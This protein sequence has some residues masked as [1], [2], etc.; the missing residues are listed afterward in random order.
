MLL[1]QP[2]VCLFGSTREP[3]RGLVH[4]SCLVPVVIRVS[5]QESDSGLRLDIKKAPIPHV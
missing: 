2:R 4:I 3:Q 5:H 1:T